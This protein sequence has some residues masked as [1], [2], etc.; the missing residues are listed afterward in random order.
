M[1]TEAEETEN[2]GGQ[3][4]RKEPSR[5]FSNQQPQQ[6]NIEPERGDSEN[7]PKKRA[8]PQVVDL[9]TKKEEASH[10]NVEV[11]LDAV[12]IDSNSAPSIIAQS[13]RGQTSAWM[14]MRKS[15]TP[16]GDVNEP[17]KIAAAKHEWGQRVAEIEA[18]TNKRGNPNKPTLSLAASIFEKHELLVGKWMLQV[19]TAKLDDVWFS[20]MDL[21]MRNKLGGC[22]TIKVSPV[23]QKRHPQAITAT[24]LICVYVPDFT[25]KA[26]VDECLAGIRRDCGWDG[27]ERGERRLYFKA[28]GMTYLDIYS[29]NKWRLPVSF[30]SHDAEKQ[31][32]PVSIR[33][34]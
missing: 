30:Y 1:A 19:S 15:C 32:E 18:T 29:N 23:P 13:A 26:S 24:H 7:P 31:A 10:D 11:S 33:R 8:L 25:D 12:R 17:Q 3:Q 5:A 22:C 14:W 27:V 20:L 4:K 34:Y 28:D 16:F 9:T 2:P 21:M 6:K